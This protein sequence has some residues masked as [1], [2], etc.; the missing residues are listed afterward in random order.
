M[1]KA[2]PHSIIK[3]NRLAF[4]ETKV[5]TVNM[6]KRDRLILECRYYNGEQDNPFAQ[7]LNAHEVDKSHLPPPECMKYEYS[8]A[9]DEVAYLHDAAK[10]WFYEHFWVTEKMREVNGFDFKSNLD[11]CQHVVNR[12]EN[13]G[14]PDELKAL[15]WNRYEHWA[16]GTF[17]GFMQWYHNFYQ[18]RPTNRQRRAEERKKTLIPMCR[19]YKGEADCPPGLQDNHNVFWVYEKMW[20]EA[21]SYS[22]TRGEDWRKTVEQEHLGAFAKKHNIPSSLVGLLFNRYKHWGHGGETTADFI[23][24]MEQQYLS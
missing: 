12:M 24:W 15:L 17:E 6:S 4:A 10:A 3:S 16:S 5:K 9:A 22:Y 14:T 18:S 21:L 20:V 23:T 8:L 7:K 11:E 19:Y 13:D 2:T 1:T